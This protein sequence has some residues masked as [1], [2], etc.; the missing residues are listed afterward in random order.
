MG[1]FKL[2]LRMFRFRSFGGTANQNREQWL[3]RSDELSSFSS[4]PIDH[5]SS[6]PNSSQTSCS[7][8]LDASSIASIGKISGL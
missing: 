8:V 1:L 7:G 3:T 5:S 2:S 6:T 4:P